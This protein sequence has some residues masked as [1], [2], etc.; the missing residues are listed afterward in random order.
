MLGKY[1]VSVKY[2]TGSSNIYLGILINLPDSSVVA[3][4]KGD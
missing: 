4:V 3:L 2:H 1:I